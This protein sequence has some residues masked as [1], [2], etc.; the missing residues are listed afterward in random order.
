MRLLQRLAGIAIDVRAKAQERAEAEAEADAPPGAG[1]NRDPVFADAAGLDLRLGAIVYRLIG[2]MARWQ[3]RGASARGSAR[4]NAPGAVEKRRQAARQRAEA[5][6]AFVRQTNLD[7]RYMPLKRPLGQEPPPRRSKAWRYLEGLA[8]TIEG[9]DDRT[10]VASACAELA[11]IVRKLG[12]AKTAE[13]IE[14]LGRA[15]LAELDGAAWRRA[16]DGC[17]R[18]ESHAPPEAPPPDTG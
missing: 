15:I 13:R 6:A 3:M 10:V 2:L 9:T 14:A 12:D 7:P 8:A 1:A 11:A 16:D 5:K 17:T 18:N 4:A